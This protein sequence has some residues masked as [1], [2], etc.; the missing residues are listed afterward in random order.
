MGFSIKRIYG[1]TEKEEEYRVLVDRIWP[2]G[3]RKDDLQLDEWCKHLGPSHDLR[4]AFAHDPAKWEMFRS[5]YFAELANQ[6]EEKNRLRA[7]A[8]K[9]NI[10]L[11]FSARDE[12]H[13]QAVVIKEWLE[14]D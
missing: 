3:I 4:R 11:L 2:R 10:M 1:L 9:H 5:A 7:L 14:Q 6:T 13:N 8:R 12:L